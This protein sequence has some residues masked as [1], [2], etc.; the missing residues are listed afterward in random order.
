MSPRAIQRGIREM[1]RYYFHIYDHT[2][3][4][5]DDEG[6]ELSGIAAALA[7]GALTVDDLVAANLRSGQ[8]VS[9]SVEIEDEFG[10]LLDA[11]PVNHLLH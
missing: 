4:I 5:S 9:T 10:N 2:T 3:L 1:A 7:E 8:V 11:L 6:L